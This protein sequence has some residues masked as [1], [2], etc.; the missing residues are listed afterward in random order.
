MVVWC[1]ERMRTSNKRHRPLRKLRAKWLPD[2]QD[3]SQIIRQ[4]VAE[5]PEQGV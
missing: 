3:I 4:A 1:A 5:V 2:F